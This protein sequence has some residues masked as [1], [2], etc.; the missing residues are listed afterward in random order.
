MVEDFVLVLLCA[1]MICCCALIRATL[2]STSLAVLSESLSLAFNFLAI[3][4]EDFWRL[5]HD[6]HVTHCDIDCWLLDASISR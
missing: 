4:S 1:P 6:S 3:V 2:I 5:S